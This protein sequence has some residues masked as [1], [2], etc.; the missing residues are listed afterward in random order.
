MF[1]TRINPGDEVEILQ[2]DSKTEKKPY[3]S[4]V[5]SVSLADNTVRIYSP[6][7]SGTLVR[8]PVREKYRL[9]FINEKG[10]FQFMATILHCLVENKVNIVIFIILDDGAHYQRR[11]FFRLHLSDKI[12]YAPV[13]RT[14]FFDN[15]GV[16]LLEGVLVDISAGGLKFA[17]KKQIESNIIQFRFSLDN[18]EFILRGQIMTEY[19]NRNAIYKHKYGTR[20]INI[21]EPKQEKILTILHNRQRKMLWVKARGKKKGGP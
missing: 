1:I 14:D 2:I 6:L 4:R 3:V 16:P 5:E 18:E 21:S 8:L 20:F 13:D 17:T 15:N 11:N 19:Y 12:N 9:K 10:I 7:S